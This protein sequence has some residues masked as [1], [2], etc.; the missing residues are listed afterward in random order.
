MLVMGASIGLLGGIATAGLM[1]G[2][3]LLPQS[4]VAIGMAA[5]FAAVVRAPITGIV[6]VLEM[7][8]DFQLLL[9]LITGSLFA[10]VVADRIG[11][12]PIYDALLEADLHK[13]TPDVPVHREPVLLE[14]VVQEGSEMDGKAIKAL[15]L[16]ARCLFVT[17]T[18]HGDDL[19][20]NGETILQRGDHITAVL[21]G[22]GA[23]EAV[24]RLLPL[25]KA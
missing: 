21:S 14:F 3:G 2:M 25:S 4:F 22:A 19:L 9:P 11:T 18:R 6:L 23:G 5:F 20:P 17:I 13:A 10:L 15:P 8:D 12:P 24:V 7:T 1:P 16:P